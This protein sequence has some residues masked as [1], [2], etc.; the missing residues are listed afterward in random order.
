M[1]S[2]RLALWFSVLALNFF[3]TALA[4]P[5]TI[6]TSLLEARSAL[7]ALKARGPLP[8]GGVILEITG[9][10]YALKSSLALTAADSGT[11]TA[12]IV[13]RPAPGAT[14]I[15]SGG[16]AL[17]AWQP[18][19]DKAVAARLPLASRT[20]VRWADL[21]AAGITDFG[22][23]EQR[24]SPGLELFFNDQQ[25]DALN[26]FLVHIAGQFKYFF[27]ISRSISALL[28][29]VLDHGRRLF[30]V[31]VSGVD[32]LAGWKFNLV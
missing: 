11:A 15:L 20:P 14:V 21:R 23:I 3:A 18:V 32:F 13:W 12:P 24:G 28:L 1:S 25:F 5:L 17:T 2:P 27:A 31:L 8:T 10:V 26:L 6:T 22:Q 9:G 29:L 4:A 30:H 19:T 7:A 16:H